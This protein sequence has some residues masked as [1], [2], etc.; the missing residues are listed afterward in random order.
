MELE[1][2]LSKKDYVEASKFYLKD[3]L[4]KRSWVFILLIIILIIRLSGETF[5]WW[6]F[7]IALIISL[8]IVIVIFYFIPLFIVFI[9]LNKALAKDKSGL[10]KKRLTVTD[11][12]L[13]I[14]SES[15]SQVRKWESIVSA[16]SN[17]KF[18]YL[19]LADKKMVGFPQRTFSNESEAINCLG[20]IQSQIIRIRGSS[21]VHIINNTNNNP[22][23]F[24]GLVCLIPMFGAIAG[25]IFIINGINKY[26]DKW[27]VIMG[28]GGILFTVCFWYVVFY[29]NSFGFQGVM[30]QASQRQL[31]SLMKDVEF[32]KIKNGVYPDNLDQLNN[33]NSDISIYD[34]LTPGEHLN[35]SNEYNYQKVGDHYYLFSSGADGIPNTKDDI[36]PQVAKADS[37]KF[38]L[39]RKSY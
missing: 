31:N 28:A 12:G 22:S 7:L 38:G 25:I 18:I 1:F 14:E 30:I 5:I 17:D 15:K 6:R 24:V 3:M 9:R 19:I 11:E 20:L 29:S 10:E 4:Q 32:Y 27:F 34:P 37:A 13:L 2:Q 23:Y 8:A 21:N 35:K 33:D 36:Y 26:K 39:I 16:Q